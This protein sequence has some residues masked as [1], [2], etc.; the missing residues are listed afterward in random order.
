MIR[1]RYKL[2]NKAKVVEVTLENETTLGMTVS[3]LKISENWVNRTGVS[4]LRPAG[5]SVRETVSS[6]PRR[7]FVNNENTINLRNIF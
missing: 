4:K 6:V 3:S 1:V 5:I 7:H 2:P